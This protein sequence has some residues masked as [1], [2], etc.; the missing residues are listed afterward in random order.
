MPQDM[1][2]ALSAYVTDSVGKKGSSPEARIN[3]KPPLSQGYRK[4]QVFHVKMCRFVPAPSTP[5]TTYVELANMSFDDVS[6]SPGY[7][8]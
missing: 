8:R 5:R 2:D 7:P 4:C 1:E 3:E 6:A